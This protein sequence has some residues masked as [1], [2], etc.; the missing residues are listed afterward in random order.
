MEHKNKGSTAQI[1]EIQKLIADNGFKFRHKYAS[2][3]SQM[4]RS[5]IEETI[6]QCR[7]AVAQLKKSHLKGLDN[8]D[9]PSFTL[10][11]PLHLPIPSL[12]FVVLKIYKT[13]D[14]KL[15]TAGR[16]NLNVSH[17]TDW[18]RNVEI[19]VSHLRKHQSSKPLQFIDPTSPFTFLSQQQILQLK[20]LKEWSSNDSNENEDT[21]CLSNNDGEEEDQA[22]ESNDNSSRDSSM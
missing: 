21:L 10:S 18:V 15:G 7:L 2:T 19:I 14:V 4:C 6:I 5:A 16:G 9:V 8:L 17:S 12:A 1:S 22:L 11:Q 20:N 3:W 13:F